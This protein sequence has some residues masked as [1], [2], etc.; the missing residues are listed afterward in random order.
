MG[1]EDIMERNRARISKGWPPLSK[2]EIAELKHEVGTIHELHA[3]AAEDFFDI[4]LRAIDENMYN[5]IVIDSIGNIL[6]AAEQENESVHD[7]VYGGTSG[8]NTTFLKKMTNMLTMR[9]EY[10]EVRDSCIIGVNQIRD[11]IKNPNKNY[12]APGGNSLE[13]AKLVDVYLESGPGI[14]VQGAKI[15]TP[16]GLKPDYTPYAKNVKWRIEKG[17][18]GIHEGAYGVYL[19]DFRTNSADYYTDTIITGLTH[20]IIE[21][22]GAWLTVLGPNGE[23]ILRANGQER[24]YDA[25]AA[26]AAAKANTDDLSVMDY[27]RDSVF[28]KNNIDISYDWEDM[29]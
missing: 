28:R 11:D 10:G 24:L 14:P 22:S 19:Y 18:A 25:L 8:P 1:D 16:E 17:K 12:R 4:I 9:T 27:I 20:G 7:K 3:M 23:Q 29:K 13:H 21:G 5:L 2:E 15:R 26:D 6:A